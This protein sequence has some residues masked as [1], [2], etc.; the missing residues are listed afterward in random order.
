MADEHS[1]SRRGRLTNLVER[2][3]DEALQPYR[4]HPHPEP[5]TRV[6]PVSLEWRPLG[7]REQGVGEPVDTRHAG[8][9][10]VD[11]GRQRADRDFND[12][13]NAELTILSE[14]AMATDVDSAM[15]RRLG[16]V[17]A[18]RRNNCGE[19]LAAQQELSRA[20]PQH[21]PCIRRVR[22]GDQRTVINVLQVS[23]LSA[24]HNRAGFRLAQ[25]RGIVGRRARALS[26]PRCVCTAS[27]NVQII[28]DRADHI[29]VLNRCRDAM[30]VVGEEPKT[31]NDKH[32]TRDQRD[33]RDE[34]RLRILMRNEKDDADVYKRAHEQTDLELRNPVLQK[35][36]KEARTEQRRNHRKHEQRDRENKGEHSRD[37]A[38]HGR[39]NRARRRCCPWSATRGCE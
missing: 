11:R 29:G 16:R 35:P 30:A 23:T 3:L 5:A 19:R 32:P 21:V 28:D 31:H 15:D 37:R 36:V 9:G 1:R 14:C 2:K 6:V 38:H 33:L 26:R 20:E 4:R 34:R 10:I 39:E 7:R 8:V 25:N 22:G 24:R 27:R 12:L 18:A 17:S 13:C